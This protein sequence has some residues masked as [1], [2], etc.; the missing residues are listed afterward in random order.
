MY[1]E[2]GLTIKAIKIT[3]FEEDCYELT[4][5]TEN[6]GHFHIV[7]RNNIPKLLEEAVIVDLLQERLN[8]DA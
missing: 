4:F 7:G 1:G 8:L 2:I 6:D 5:T 3:K